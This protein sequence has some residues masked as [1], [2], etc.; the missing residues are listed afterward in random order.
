MIHVDFKFMKNLSRLICSVALASQL[1]CLNGHAAFNDILDGIRG[2]FFKLAKENPAELVKFRLINKASQAAVEEAIAQAIL[3]GA[4]FNLSGKTFTDQQFITLFT[5][6]GLFSKITK[7]N[8]SNARFNHDLLSRLP[9]SLIHLELIGSWLNSEDA[10]R[11]THL[12]NLTSLGAEFD[13]TGKTFTDEQFIALFT[14]DGLFSKITKLNLSKTR[15]NH[16]LLSKLPISLVYL[17]LSS[18]DLYAKDA[19][20]LTHL[21]NLTGLDLSKNQL[22]DAGAAHIAT[23]PNITDLYLSEN[24]ISHAGADSIA[25]GMPNIT[26]LDL[27]YNQIGDTGAT[28]I[29]TMANIT[30]LY[31]NDVEIGNAGADRL[32]TMSNLTCLHIS[33]NQIGNAGA[34][35]LATMS[36]LTSLNITKNQI[37]NAAY[38][39]LRERLPNTGIYF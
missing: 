4:T 18:C 38:G 14:G 7:L 16:D 5:G 31:L 20:I 35:S 12:T 22:G 24:Q 9:I 26:S 34:D 17:N 28:H 21:E 37:G 15:F 1:V 6:D 39:I 29:A 8:L 25:G 2:T 30:Y 19:Q 32:A 27:N 33:E 10:E 23:M 11:L 36:N 3:D 13:L